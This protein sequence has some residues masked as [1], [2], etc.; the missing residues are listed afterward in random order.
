MIHLIC[1][2]YPDWFK[3]LDH[4]SSN[5]VAATLEDVVGYVSNVDK[6]CIDVETSPKEEYKNYYLAGLDPHTSNIVMLQ[7]GDYD[8]QYVIDVRD[9]TYDD[10]ELLFQG[11]TRPDI[12]LIGHNIVF[13]LKM[14][15]SNF[16]LYIKNANCTYVQ[17]KI[18]TNGN[19]MSGYSL[20]VLTS[21][22]IRKMY[23]SKQM[24]LY[25]A[26]IETDDDTIFLTKDIRSNFKFI[27]SREFTYDEVVYGA[28][29]VKNTFDI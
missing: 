6:V 24:N 15:R 1:K 10:L 8:H 9:Y 20:E 2:N 25:K 13:D 27:G 14:L 4:S 12:L 19:Q 23:R 26:P 7:I 22:Y 3:L 29:D 21:K 17:E 28:Y 16:G 18:I 5:V 11:L